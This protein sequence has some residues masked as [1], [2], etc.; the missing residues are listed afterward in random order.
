LPLLLRPSAAARYLGMNKN[1]FS[2]LVRPHV[3]VIPI[4]KRAIAFHRLELDAWAEDYCRR[5]GRLARQ[6]EGQQC[7]REYPASSGE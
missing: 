6:L 3:R 2:S 5:N 1:C 4:G 7:R